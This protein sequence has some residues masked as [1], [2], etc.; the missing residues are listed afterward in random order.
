VKL[1]ERGVGANADE[2]RKWPGLDG[3]SRMKRSMARAPV[4]QVMAARLTTA[5]LAPGTAVLFLVR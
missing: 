4:G 3:F 5:L 2:N 1:L